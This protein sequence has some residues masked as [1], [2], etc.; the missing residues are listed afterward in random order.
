MW[1]KTLIFIDCWWHHWFWIVFLC[2]FHT[3]SVKCIYRLFIVRKWRYPV[4][5]FF[6][7]TTVYTDGI[8]IVMFRFMDVL[9]MVLDVFIMIW[10]FDP[11]IDNFS[12]IDFWQTI[13]PL[14]I[15]LVHV[16]YTTIQECILKFINFRGTAMS[17]YLEV[18]QLWSISTLWLP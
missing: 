16:T 2:F 9:Q 8:T 1:W 4:Y 3:K 14:L 10:G 18:Y 6:F 15:K 7:I 17:L 5:W 11:V 13:N 12:I